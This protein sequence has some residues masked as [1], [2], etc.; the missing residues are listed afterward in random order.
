M[1][2]YGG[3][4]GQFVRIRAGM[5][6][7]LALTTL[8]KIV[9]VA[10]LAALL[11]ACSPLTALNDLLVPSNGW[12]IQRDL[13]YGTDERQRL[14]IYTPASL[15]RPAPVVVFLYGGAWSGGRR[16]WYRFVGEALTGR[17]YVVVIPDY[18]VYPEVRFPVFVEDAAAAVA[19][20][21]ANAASF[22]GDPNRIF[23]MGHSAGA[24][25]AALLVTD[26]SYLAAQGFGVSTV[27]GLIGLAGPYTFDPSLYSSTRSI[28]ASASGVEATQPVNFVQ[29]GEPPML[30]LH[31]AADTTVY[32]VN[33][34]A[35]ADRVRAKGGSVE[36]I[37]Y[38]DTGH[39]RLVLELAR[40]FR[41]DGGV[42]DVVGRFIDAR[43]AAVGT[44]APTA[45]L[46]IAPA[47]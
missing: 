40:P 18:R 28:F 1:R 20:A 34:F 29:G 30:L 27:R 47:P 36:T 15:N 12:G 42:L 14:D 41:R 35:L 5:P 16:A 4:V 11:S 37:E 38:P 22:G 43:D 31:G 32:P 7:T 13:A 3:G 24:H 10:L 8:R 46:P 2:R 26:R 44:F 45:T 33:S 25:I 17:G 23:L 6:P 9:L 39:I 19:W 21:R